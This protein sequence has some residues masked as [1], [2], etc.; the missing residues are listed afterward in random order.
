MSYRS[1]CPNQCHQT[2]GK[3]PGSKGNRRRR[4]G[5]AMILWE[6]SRFGRRQARQVPLF[7][8]ALG[9]RLKHD[10]RLNAYGNALGFRV[11]GWRFRLEKTVLYF[12]RRKSCVVLMQPSLMH[13]L[14][15]V[16]KV[17]P[18]RRRDATIG[19]RWLKPSPF[20][21]DSVSG[22][23]SQLRSKRTHRL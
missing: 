3:Q 23:A 8:E 11:G 10:S 6:E 20:K 7:T 4:R 15:A 21:D 5:Q 22:G 17:I 14:S 12:D 2:W 1:H 18:K 19:A 9:V 16:H 13:Q